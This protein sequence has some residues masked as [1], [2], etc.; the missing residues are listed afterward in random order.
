M[1]GGSIVIAEM[2]RSA[3][4]NFTLTLFIIALIFSAVAIMRSPRLDQSVIAE[5]LISWFVFFC[6][7]VSFFYNFIMHGFFGEMTASFIG[8]ADSPFQ[9]EV[10]TASLGFSV[11]GFLAAFGS[12]DRRLAAIIG[13]AC[14]LLGAAYGHV[15]EMVTANNFAPGNAGVIFYTDIFIPLFGFFLHWL[16]KRSKSS[17]IQADPAR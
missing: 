11:V 14:F 16:Q 4:S 2:V 6:I 1:N 12:F 15:D 8:W 5:K 3:L 7:G 13:P 9:F 10:A 17:I